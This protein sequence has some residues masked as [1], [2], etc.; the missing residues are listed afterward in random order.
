[1]G[2]FRKNGKQR[3]GRGPKSCHNMNNWA[4]FFRPNSSSHLQGEIA[5]DIYHART[6]VPEGMPNGGSAP[7]RTIGSSVVKTNIQQQ[8]FGLVGARVHRKSM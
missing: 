6:G 1:M 8:K 2:L 7:K 3:M 4:N 5:C